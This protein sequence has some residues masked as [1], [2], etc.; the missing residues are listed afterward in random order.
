MP[1]KENSKLRSTSIDSTPDSPMF[2]GNVAPDSP[3]V[4]VGIGSL[5]KVR[6]MEHDDVQTLYDGVSITKPAAITKKKIMGG[7]REEM[8]LAPVASHLVSLAPPKVTTSDEHF[9]GG[10]STDSPAAKSTN[11]FIMQSHAQE[12]LSF[13]RSALNSL[14]GGGI[15]TSMGKSALTKSF[16]QS[17]FGRAGSKS[18]SFGKIGHSMTT[19]SLEVTG[20]VEDV[21]LSRLRR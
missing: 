12:L 10:P 15:A 20:T 7:S 17:T 21:H 2:S 4:H 9:T 8:Q 18:A 11:N 14:Q 19:I 16:R 3:H 1:P 6:S 13:G 5:M